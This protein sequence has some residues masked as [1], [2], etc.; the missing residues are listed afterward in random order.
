MVLTVVKLVRLLYYGYVTKRDPERA[1]ASHALLDLYA[2][3]AL[4]AILHAVGAIDGATAYAIVLDTA[5]TVI[6]LQSVDSVLAIVA[7]YYLVMTS[8]TQTPSSPGARPGR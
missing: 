7:P 3:I 1:R 6:M 2:T 8:A 5:I 4:S